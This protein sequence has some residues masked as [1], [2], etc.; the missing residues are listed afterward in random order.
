MPSNYELCQLISQK[1]YQ[2]NLKLNIAD[3]Y[4]RVFAEQESLGIIERIPDD[5]KPDQHIFIPH[6]AVIKSDP[7]TTTKVRPV[8]NCSLKIKGAPSLNEAAHPGPDMMSD[9]VGLL[10]YFRT[11]KYILLADIEKAFLMIRLRRLSDKNSI[12]FILYRNGKFVPYRYN[13]IIFGFCS[14]PFILN[15]VLKYHIEKIRDVLL[16]EALQDRFYVDNFIYTT[17]NKSLLSE[18]YSSAKESLAQGGFNLRDWLSNSESFP[19]C[20]MPNDL[21]DGTSSKVLGYKYDASKDEMAVRTTMLNASAS[22]KR[23][24]LSSI[25]KIFDPLG[26]LSPLTIRGKFILRKIAQDKLSWDAQIPQEIRNQ[27]VKLCQDMETLGHI[28]LSR[29]MV[30]DSEPCKVFIFCDA[31]SEGYGFSSYFVQNGVSNFFFAKDKVSPMQKKTLPTLELLAAYLGLKCVLNLLRDP[32]LS[33]LKVDSISLFSDSQ[34]ALSWLL[35]KKAT[36]KNVFINNRLREI[37]TLEESCVTAQI[38]FE[39]KYV[40]TQHNVADIVS[41]GVNVASFKSS[42]NTWLRGPDWILKDQRYWPSGQ[43]G[44][45]PTKHILA[46][47][48]YFSSFLNFS[49]FRSW[50]QL[51]GVMFYIIKF[52]HILKK[53]S[54]TDNQIKC[55]AYQ[56][57]IKEM[58]KSNFSVELSYLTKL[59]SKSPVPLLVSQLGLFLDSHGLIR[60]KGRIEKCSS[61]DS[62]ALNPVI[63]HKDHPITRLIIFDAHTRCK[64]LGAGSTINVLR[65]GGIWIP[66]IRQ[67]VHKCLKN[68]FTCKRINAKAFKYPPPPSLPSDRVNLTRAFSTIGVDFTGHFFVNDGAG[69]S[70]SYILIFTCM[71][72]RSIH[73]ELLPSMSTEEFVLAFVR[74]TNFFGIPKVVYSDNAKT[75]LAASNILSDFFLSTEFSQKFR[76]SSISFRTIPVYAAWFGATWERLIKV[77]KDCIYKTFGRS[78]ISSTNFRTALSDIQLM[79]NNRP[80]T[81]RTKEG[82]LDVL[83][84]NHFLNLGDLSPS[85]VLSESTLTMLWDLDEEEQPNALINALDVR[86]S[87]QEKFREMW[88]H[89]YLLSLR[90]QHLSS[91]KIPSNHPSLKVGSILML[92]NPFKPRIF[93]SLVKIVDLIPSKD[94]NIRVVKIQRSDGS[95]TT[96]AISNLYP[97]ELHCT[98]TS[99]REVPS[100]EQ[101]VTDMELSTP[102]NIPDTDFSIQEPSNSGSNSLEPSEVRS[103]PTRGAAQKFRSKLDHWIREGDV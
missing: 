99:H 94:G 22:S 11:N 17:S 20:V 51:M 67:A 13:S 72:T 89:S 23:E 70:K 79:I 6:R 77:V 98:R 68:C 52:K 3:Q 14:S 24:I 18:V 82:E 25:S 80:L 1:V 102:L 53:V 95:Q 29:E 88:T 34:V 37:V 101:P 45:I 27:W 49:K 62:D 26:I 63:C 61:L 33:K 28:N 38:K 32:L 35:N 7:L 85:L 54:V 103:R 39:Y 65:R 30:V 36:K 16:R 90:E 93:W 10:N 57:L 86:D 84:P 59:D 2:R 100:Q 78:T 60:S 96:A 83:T 47:M 97:L 19:L 21:L 9:L 50:T 73:L 48:T 43:L 44:C 41:R 81:Y 31:S 71:N 42:L 69:K 64:H 91:K 8:F 66:R 76:T 56:F 5:F 4:D 74:F 15:C 46:H 92:K 75:F 12:S 58:Q 40:P 87:L 55:E